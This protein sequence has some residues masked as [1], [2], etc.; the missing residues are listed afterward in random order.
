MNLYESLP[1][2]VEELKRL[3]TLRPRAEYHEDYGPVLWFLVPICEPPIVGWEEHAEKYHTHWA[4]ISNDYS[5]EPT[6]EQIAS[7]FDAC[8]EVGK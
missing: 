3:R 4:P 2:P 5:V 8:S 6:T 7:C 1:N